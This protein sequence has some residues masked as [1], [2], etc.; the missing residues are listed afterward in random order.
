MLLSL[1]RLIFLSIFFGI[2]LGGLSAYD[3]EKP[4][5]PTTEKT[6]CTFQKLDRE[7][8][9]GKTLSDKL[10]RCSYLQ[11]AW[12]S[13]L[14]DAESQEEFLRGMTV[15]EKQLDQF[16]KNLTYAATVMDFYNPDCPKTLF[17][18]TV[19]VGNKIG[20]LN[21]FKTGRKLSDAERERLYQEE[22]HQYQK[23]GVFKPFDLNEVTLKTMESGKTYNFVL[24]P[25]GSIRAALEKPGRKD[26]LFN[27]DKLDSDFAYPNHTILAGGANQAI[28]TAGSMI[29]Y[30]VEDKQLMFISNKSGHFIPSYES[31]VVLKKHLQVYGV[32]SNTVIMVPT[33][34][35]S[36]V[37]LSHYY[38]ARIQITLTNEDIVR[39]I[40]VAH[41]RW[42][43]T[44]DQMDYKLLTEVAEGHFEHL[45]RDRIMELNRIREEATYMRSAYHMFAK[46]HQAPAEYHKF[47]KKFG[48]LKDAIKHNIKEKIIKEAQWIHVFLIKNDDILKGTAFIAANSKNLQQFL[49]NEIQ[50][51]KLLI[52]RDELSLDEFHHVKKSARELGSLFLSLSEDAFETGRNFSIYEA[53]AWKLL[54]INQQMAIIH[55]EQ[56]GKIMRKEVDKEKVNLVIPQGTKNH[57]NRLLDQLTF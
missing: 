38:T 34:D 53:A 23:D 49:K 3:I 46:G 13:Y 28:L 9:Q 8:E 55:D 15:I 22:W 37:I 44:L 4:L 25:D 7:I 30:R 36:S 20:F 14:H 43:M 27:Q 5:T 52:A 39:L 41:R 47:V 17:P 21:T 45:T 6:I 51:I 35:L 12:L 29:L 48:K 56:V 33:V 50:A 32:Q 31:L 11:D 42:I 16:H 24:F 2:F 1:K 10:L 19:N 40:Q 18:Q 26:Y 57:L 54:Q